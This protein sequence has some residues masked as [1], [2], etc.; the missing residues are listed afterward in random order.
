M[1][2]DQLFTFS[3]NKK[4]RV[5]QTLAV[6]MFKANNTINYINLYVHEYYT[7]NIL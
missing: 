5:H 4:I 6:G 3:I 7:H 1:D 2:R